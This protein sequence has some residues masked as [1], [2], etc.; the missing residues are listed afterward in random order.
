VILDLEPDRWR[1]ANEPRALRLLVT[2][3]RPDVSLYYGGNWVWVRGIEVDRAGWIVDGEE[4][5]VL[6][7]VDA[8]RDDDRG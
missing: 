2:T 5:G 6:V 4:R 7:H 3:V 8:I 1:Y